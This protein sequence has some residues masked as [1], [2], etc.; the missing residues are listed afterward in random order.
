MSLSFAPSKNRIYLDNNATTCID[1]KIL[2][3]MIQSAEE[4][5]GNPSSVHWAGRLAKE[6]LLKARESLAAAFQVKPREILFTS[7]GTEGANTVIRGLF[8]ACTGHIVTS[9][10]EHACVYTTIKT[11]GERGCEVTDLSPGLHG[12][13]TVEAVEHAVRAD[14]RCIVLMA[15]N[16]ETGV[17]TDLD[18]IADFAV[19]MRIPL[20]VDGVAWL[21][22]EQF[23]L[24]K[25]VSAIWFSGHKFHAPKGI[26]FAIIRKPFRTVPLLTGGEQEYG[27]RGGTENLP[28]IEALAEA[29]RLLSDEL[30]EATFRMARLRDKLERTL[31]E[32]LPGIEVN[33]AGPRICNTTN[34]AF[35]GIDGET[36]LSLLDLHGIAV[37]HGSACSSGA[38]EPSRPLLNMGIPLERARSSLRFSLSRQTTEKEIDDTISILHQVVAQ[39]RN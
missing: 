1:P 30:P 2:R 14:T 22:K 23:T 26:G 28:A 10:A 37:S 7:S 24:P 4:A 11:L 18:A 20:L 12:A 13:V 9:S 8:P 6:R 35:S 21:G 3:V 32:T 38:L 34:L 16:N 31:I 25:G 19:R 5:Y 17:K 33:G 15:V 29:V 36:L 39:M 27:L